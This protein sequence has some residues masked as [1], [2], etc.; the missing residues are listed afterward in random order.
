MSSQSVT[1]FPNRC[2]VAASNEEL[3]LPLDSRNIRGLRYHLLTTTEPLRFISLTCP[4]YT[5]SARTALK[6]APLLQ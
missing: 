1:I 5:I 2:L 4:A 6:T 3:P